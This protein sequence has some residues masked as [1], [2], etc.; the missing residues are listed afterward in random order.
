MKN[1][2]WIKKRNKKQGDWIV[3]YLAKNCGKNPMQLNRNSVGEFILEGK[4]LDG[5]PLD[6]KQRA[7]MESAWRSYCNRNKPSKRSVAL[8][9]DIYREI[10]AR[11]KELNLSVPLFLEK[12]F[13]DL[14]DSRTGLQSSQQITLLKFEKSDM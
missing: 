7:K 6:E 2:K 1:T 9:A 8:K 4:P 5:Q 11:A 13:R 12:H 3:T 14:P 10:E